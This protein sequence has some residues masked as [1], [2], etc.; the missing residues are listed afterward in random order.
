MLQRSPKH[1]LAAAR[2]GTPTG[3]MLCV[4]GADGRVRALEWADK[5]DRFHTLLARYQGPDTALEMQEATPAI[6]SRALA[7]YFEGDFAATAAIEVDPGGTV[8]QKEAW[9]ALRRIPP[10]ETRTYAEQA[11]IIGRPAA[12]RAVG[13][14][15]GANPVAIIVPCHRVIG[16]DGSLTGFGG[17]IERK[18]WLLAHERAPVAAVQPGLFG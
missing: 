1:T 4:W 11:A 5:D 9:A 2:I 10:G 13:A 16:A 6:I 14:A 18:R 3:D 12:V 15:N 7:A 17:G 8:F